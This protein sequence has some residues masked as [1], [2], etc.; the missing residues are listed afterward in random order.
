MLRQSSYFKEPPGG[1]GICHTWYTSA[2]SG[3]DLPETTRSS[4]HKCFTHI[5]EC[6]AEPDGKANV[7]HSDKGTNG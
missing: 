7:L 1:D 4:Q 3:R 5:H 6:Q 2:I